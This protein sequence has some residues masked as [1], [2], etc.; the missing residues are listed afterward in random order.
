MDQNAFFR[1]PIT[2]ENL[3][4]LRHCLKVVGSLHQIKSKLVEVLFS[5]Y[6][7]TFS[8][9]GG[10]DPSPN[11]LRHLKESMVGHGVGWGEC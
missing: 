9:G 6:V 11:L 10:V 5:V 2:E 3:F 1:G 7:W 4:L 8:R